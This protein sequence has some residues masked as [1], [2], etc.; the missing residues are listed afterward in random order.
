MHYSYTRVTKMINDS[1]FPLLKLTSYARTEC[2][3]HHCV[4]LIQKPTDLE[5]GWIYKLRTRSEKK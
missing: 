2:L 4:Q 3:G 1:I 5:Q